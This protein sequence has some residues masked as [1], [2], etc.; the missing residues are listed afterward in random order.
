MPLALLEP[1]FKAAAELAPKYTFELV[2]ADKYVEPLENKLFGPL[3]ISLLSS[4]LLL[5]HFALRVKATASVFGSIE[6]STGFVNLLLF[7]IAKPTPITMA[8]PASAVMIFLNI[9][10]IALPPY[11]KPLINWA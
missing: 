4:E 6:A 3:V 11:K 10:F 8:M 2:A 1:N 7:A 9:L 5:L